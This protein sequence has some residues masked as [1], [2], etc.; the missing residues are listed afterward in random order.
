MNIKIFHFFAN[1]KKKF[2]LRIFNL[3]YLQIFSGYITNPTNCN[4]NKTQLNSL[5]TI[6]TFQLNEIGNGTKFSSFKVSCS[7]FNPTLKYNIPIV[8]N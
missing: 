6:T 5:G 4:T 3:K 7:F 1:R 2:Y 8:N